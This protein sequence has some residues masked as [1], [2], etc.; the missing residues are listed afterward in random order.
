MANRDGA[1]VAIEGLGRAGDLPDSDE[2]PQV[3][4]SNLLCRPSVSARLVRL[5]RVDPPQS[6]GRTIDQESIAINNSN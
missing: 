1:S 2:G 5:G 4:G 6:I 3:F